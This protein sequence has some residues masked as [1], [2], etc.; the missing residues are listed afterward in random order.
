MVAWQHQ[1][2]A[3]EHQ[4]RCQ[5]PE[6]IVEGVAGR[7]VFSFRPQNAVAGWK[8]TFYDGP[9]EVIDDNKQL[10]SSALMIV[11]LNTALL[12]I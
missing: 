4:A 2:V 10:I 3:K 12:M 6:R 11:V 7:N 9:V 1:P 5:G 8:L